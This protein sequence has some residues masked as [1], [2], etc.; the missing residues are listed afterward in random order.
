M[1]RP[2]PAVFPWLQRLHAFRN[3]DAEEA[4]EVAKEADL[5]LVRQVHRPRDPIRLKAPLHNRRSAVADGLGYVRILVMDLA[6]EDL[7]TETTLGFLP[8]NHCFF[9]R[10]TGC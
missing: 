8:G 6:H 4:A 3:L 10:A 2:A 7:L 1:E 9:N 5:A